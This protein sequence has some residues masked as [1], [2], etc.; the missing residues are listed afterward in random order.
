MSELK[1][2][3]VVTGST[4][5]LGRHLIKKLLIQKSYNI[6]SLVR[7][8]TKLPN[9]CI[10]SLCDILDY[11]SISETIA[12]SDIIIH[13]ASLVGVSSC[14]K[15]HHNS[16]DINVLG[17]LNVLD[18]ARYYNKP[19]VFSGV[20]NV[21][22]FSIYSITKAT[23]ERFLM[24]YNGE[25]KTNFIPLRI[26]NVY[27]P[28]QDLKSG[29]LIVNSI[30][31]GLKG[32]PINIYG[33][34]SQVMDFI[35]VDDVIDQLEYSIKHINSFENKPYDI[36]T[37]QGIS[38]NDVVKKIINMT[39]N[40]SKINFIQKRSGDTMPR[41][42][43]NKNKFLTNSLPFHQLEKGLEKTINYIKKYF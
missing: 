37:G 29:K 24:M 43:A 4:G 27:G 5:F 21:D 8:S 22:D 15:N 19:V 7:D 35:Y 31:K 40:K 32:E 33:D 1:K 13:L 23:A 12:R 30:H 28:G 9:E 20:S 10:P 26:F 6:I 17:T 11:E 14:D 16:I 3:I 34:G 25:H 18:A 38:I 39:G 41:V 36:G 2:N 42:I